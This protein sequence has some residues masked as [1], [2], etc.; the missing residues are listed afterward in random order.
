MGCVFCELG[1]CVT[2]VVREY[3]YEEDRARRYRRELSE[4]VSLPKP[5]LIFDIRQSSGRSSDLSSR[6]GLLGLG[7]G[8][9]PS[10]DTRPLQR[11]L[12]TEP[13]EAENAR[14][15]ALE[16]RQRAE[17][18]RLRREATAILDEIADTVRGI[19]AGLKDV[20]DMFSKIGQHQQKVKDYQELNTTRKEMETAVSQRLLQV[21]HRLR[22]IRADINT[23]SK[24]KR[25]TPWHCVAAARK[26]AA[27]LLP[28]EERYN[29]VSG[30]LLEV[31]LEVKPVDTSSSSQKQRAITFNTLTKATDLVALLPMSCGNALRLANDMINHPLDGNTGFVADGQTIY[32]SS[33]GSARAGSTRGSAFWT[34]TN[35]RGTLVAM[36]EHFGNSSDTYKITWLASGRQVISTTA[37]RVQLQN[38]KM[39]L[40]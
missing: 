25:L 38:Q 4:E 24:T 12:L 29:I 17:D 32:H 27:F 20:G 9:I 16:W 5:R 1:L 36:G 14:T 33:K 19:R 8:Y 35:S 23:V 22:Q 18:E 21:G 28:A 40:A 30:A 2:H 26:L 34:V 31:Y 3:D 39:R 7:L 13:W 15:L 10:F 37:K 11:P 6:S